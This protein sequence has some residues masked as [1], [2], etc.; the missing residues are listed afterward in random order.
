MKQVFIIIFI[1]I[2]VSYCYSQSQT[3]D[4][5]KSKSKME[6]FSLSTGQITKFTDYKLPNVKTSYGGKECR[7]RV[8]TRGSEIRYYYQIINKTQ[9]KSLVSS[10]EYSDLLEV[11][12]AYNQLKSEA[13]QDMVSNPEY[14][15]NYFTTI[16]DDFTFGY[17]VSKGKINWYMTIGNKYN[18]ENI[19]PNSH[20]DI[21]EAFG[22]AKTKIEE[23]M[24]KK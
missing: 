16:D 18:N 13:L 9:Y 22:S 23:L 20:T 11:M 15:E 3:D 19:F 12:K 8:F 21:E 2:S 4:K 5:E 24:A 17:Y 7:V 14:L 1:I 6:Q 10:I